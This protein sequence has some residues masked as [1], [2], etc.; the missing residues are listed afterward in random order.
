MLH[1]NMRPKTYAVSGTFLTFPGNGDADTVHH[2]TPAD[3]PEQ[4]Q[5]HRQLQCPLPH[6]YLWILKWPSDCQAM[7][8]T[9]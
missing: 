5:A 7:V 1:L 8:Y 9:P 4:P 6:R 2:L 3:T